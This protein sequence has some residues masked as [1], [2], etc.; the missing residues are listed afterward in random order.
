M[1][2]CSLSCNLPDLCWA[3]FL[4]H[5]LWITRK[6]WDC[7]LYGMVGMVFIFESRGWICE[8]APC[9]SK[10]VQ[11]VHLIGLGIWKN[12]PFEH[13]LGKKEHVSILLS[14]GDFHFDQQHIKHT[15]TWLVLNHQN[16]SALIFKLLWGPLQIQWFHIQNLQIKSCP[17]Y[18]GIWRRTV[19]WPI[20][21]ENWWLED[22]IVFWEGLISKSMFLFRK[23]YRLFTY[24]NLLNYPNVDK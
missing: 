23:G 1:S 11:N 19:F 21:P 8:T 7:H 15:L 17:G 5:Q 13:P 18:C 4:N 9:D 24:I 6:K 12:I 2:I 22:N 20:Y 10:I 3:G 14:G 16:W